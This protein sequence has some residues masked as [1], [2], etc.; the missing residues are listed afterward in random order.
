[1]KADI[2]AQDRSYR[3]GLV[4]GFTLAEVMVLIIFAL[5]L[6]LSWHLVAKDKEIDRLSQSLKEK[7]ADVITLTELTI[8]L[9]ARIEQFERFDDFDDLFRELEQV[10]KKRAAQEQANAAL[11][12][13]VEAL[14]RENDALEE[15]A[16]MAERI[17]EIAREA[18]VPT[19]DPEKTVQE[20]ASRLEQLK[21]VKEGMKAVG[22]D[23]SQ[24]KEFVENTLGKLAEAEHPSSPP[25]KNPALIF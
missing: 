5:L 24:V 9:K 15:R 25:P 20:I 13:K 22:L 10:K 18:H 6:A 4:L 2:S 12:E 3:R 8:K 7:E 1:M 17:M 14:E 11:R 16:A 23:D 21:K 19:E